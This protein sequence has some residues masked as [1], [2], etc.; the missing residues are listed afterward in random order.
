[1]IVLEEVLLELVDQ[2]SQLWFRQESAE[3]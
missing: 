3:Q 2:L 1:M